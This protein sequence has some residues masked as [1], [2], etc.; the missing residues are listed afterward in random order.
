MKTRIIT[1]QDGSTIYDKNY[2]HDGNLQ[3]NKG[4]SNI[5]EMYYLI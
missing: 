1:K 3:E 5:L 4:F 2:K